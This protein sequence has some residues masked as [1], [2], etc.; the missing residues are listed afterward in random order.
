MK[1][2]HFLFAWAFVVSSSSMAHAVGGGQV[3]PGLIPGTTT[4]RN[5]VSGG[6]AQPAA[7]DPA[8]DTRDGKNDYRLTCPHSDQHPTVDSC[9]NYMNP[10]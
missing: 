4:D 2:I 6:D 10:D 9:R 8:A 5:T 1:S 3:Y 7:V